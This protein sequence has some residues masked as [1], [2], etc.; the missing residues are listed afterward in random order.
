VANPRLTIEEGSPGAPGLVLRVAG[1]LDV[2]TAPRFRARLDR[3]LDA[4][5]REIVIDL[6]RVT[7]IDSI[8]L[9]VVMAARQRL[10][11]DGRLAIVANTPFVVLI[12]EASGLD[13]VLDV[14]PDCGSA[15]AFAFA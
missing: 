12:L 10:M 7:F 14:F 1:E 15:K 6:T 13:G 8:A 2:A 9:A 5:A 4:G 3:A 11:P